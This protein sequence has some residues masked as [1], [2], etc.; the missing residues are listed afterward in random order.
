MHILSSSVVQEAVLKLPSSEHYIVEKLGT[1][2]V[3]SFIGYSGQLRQANTY[4]L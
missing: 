1:F 2:I 4:T 3:A